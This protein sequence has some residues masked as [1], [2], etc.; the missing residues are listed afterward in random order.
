MEERLTPEQRHGFDEAVKRQVT[1]NISIPTSQGQADIYRYGVFAAIL[2]DCTDNER[3]KADEEELVDDFE[4]VA[5]AA[6]RLTLTGGLPPKWEEVLVFRGP[7]MLGGDTH[8]KFD[9]YKKRA[10]AT[11]F[12]FFL[13]DDKVYV[14]ATG[15]YTGWTKEQLRAR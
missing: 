7:H 1:V 6:T 9:A 3:A 2:G 13:Y 11:Y 10:T 15:W 8:N 4:R 12:P 14:T 5:N